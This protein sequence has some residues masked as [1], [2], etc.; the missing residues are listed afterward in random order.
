MSL[1][2]LWEAAKK[3][4]YPV[5]DRDELTQSLG[6][7]RIKFEGNAFDTRDIAL[8]INEYPIHDPADLI[9]EFLKEDEAFSEEEGKK[10]SETLGSMNNNKKKKK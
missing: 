5:K 8:Q 3:L 10:L 9:H 4:R 7:L 1:D 6:N 2:V